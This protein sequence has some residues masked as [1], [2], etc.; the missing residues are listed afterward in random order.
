MIRQ[1]TKLQEELTAKKNQMTSRPVSKWERTAHLECVSKNKAMLENRQLKEALHEQLTFLNQMERVFQKK[2]Q[3]HCQLILLGT[4]CLNTDDWT[5]YKLAAKT[6]LRYTAIHAI[7]DRQYVRMQSVFIQADVMHRADDLFHVRAIPHA[8]SSSSFLV[9]MVHHMTLSAPFSVVG[10]AAWQVFD[11]ETSP[12]LPIGAI[13]ACCDDIALTMERM[14]PFTVY[15]RLE[16]PPL[17]PSGAS[18]HSNMIRKYYVEPE[19]HVIVSRTVV[20]DAA[21]PHMTFG[22]VEDRC[23]WDFVDAFVVGRS[24]PK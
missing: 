14:D 16:T 4:S 18:G 2:P 12:D 11:G 1:V 24:F 3:V 9:E 5:A 15:A 19:R 8:T 21:V 20:E 23:V 22:A 13:E 6:S 17:P 7:A 10:M